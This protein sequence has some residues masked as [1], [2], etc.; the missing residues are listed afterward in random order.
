MRAEFGTKKSRRAACFFDAAWADYFDAAGAA[1]DGAID[2]E[3]VAFAFLAFFALGA[4][5]EAD[6]DAAAGAEAMAEAEADAEGAAKA[7]VANRET[8]RAAIILDIWISF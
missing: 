5:A 6:A 3:A 2:A 8:N 1:T 7:A 4:D